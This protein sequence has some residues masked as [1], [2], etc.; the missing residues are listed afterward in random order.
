MDT[1]TGEQKVGDKRR[2]G[3]QVPGRQDRISNASGRERI[4]RG[5]ASVQKK[6]T[7]QKPHKKK[8]M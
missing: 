2:A 1:Q 4:M 6:R 7:Q 3:K 5:G 8:K